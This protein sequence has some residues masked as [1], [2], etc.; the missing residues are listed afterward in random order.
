MTW[1]KRGKGEAYCA[2]Q[3][4]VKYWQDHVKLFA[5]VVLFNV[6]FLSL[7]AVL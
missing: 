5:A 7:P 3:I 1:D 4:A 2:N 6:P